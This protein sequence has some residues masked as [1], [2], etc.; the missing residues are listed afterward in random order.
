MVL[1]KSTV[2]N[3]RISRHCKVGLFAIHLF[4]K[5]FLHPAAA[6]VFH[7]IGKGILPAIASNKNELTN[8]SHCIGIHVG[9]GRKRRT[10]GKSRNGKRAPG[11]SLAHMGPAASVV[12]TESGQLVK[13][14]TSSRGKVSRDRLG[15]QKQ[16]L[17]AGFLK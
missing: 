4:C 9:E 1:Q 5:I 13:G 3:L 7:F 6:K 17:L 12:M 16:K 8:I 11:S 14:L 2:T 15:K 10:C